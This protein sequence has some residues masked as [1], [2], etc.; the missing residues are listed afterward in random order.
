[1]EPTS[2]SVKVLNN[3][4]FYFLLF[5]MAIFLNSNAQEKRR[6]PKTFI[7]A[8]S[9]YIGTDIEKGRIGSATV[10]PETDSTVLFYVEA[11]RGAPSYNMGQLYGRLKLINGQGVFYSNEKNSGKSCKFSCNFKS[12]QMIVKTLDNEDNCG[13]GFGV[14]ID[15]AFKRRSKKIPSYFEDLTGSKIYFRKTSPENWMA[16]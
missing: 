10:Y 16:P 1:M 9:Y 13:F 8:G 4:N 6:Y 7:Y 2:K 15:G 3:R 14:Y 12:N 5:T 11:N